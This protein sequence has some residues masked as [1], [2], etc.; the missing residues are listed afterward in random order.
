MTALF[1]RL[2][3]TRLYASVTV[4]ATTGLRRGELLALRWSDVDL[5]AATI[6][7]RRAL[8]ETKDGLNFKS[9]KTKKAQRML[10]LLPF[11]VEVL[12][13]HRVEQAKARLAAGMTMTW[14]FPT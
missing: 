6:M 13:S 2:A 4:A 5:D 1:Y 14:F 11:T 3:G 12:R 10:D 8:E 7:V 9:P